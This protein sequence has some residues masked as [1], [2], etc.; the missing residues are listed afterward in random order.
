MPAG[1]LPHFRQT[2][3]TAFFMTERA[4][5][6]ANRPDTPP[7][8][9]DAD[10]QV[11]S[12]RQVREAR[13]WELVEDYIELISDLIADTGRARQTDIA[14]RLGVAQP[15][16]ARMIKRLVAGGLLKSRPYVGIE[17]TEQGEAL[18]RASRDRHRLVEQFLCALGVPE[19]VARRDAE[20]IEHH[21]SAE[22]LQAFSQFLDARRKA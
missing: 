8:L 7:E 1:R 10:I 2:C 16:V 22:T 19:D 6:R 15:T 21:V 18:A 5:R 11:E 13:R 4:S 12:F 20:G 3:F 14:M 17:L 9:L